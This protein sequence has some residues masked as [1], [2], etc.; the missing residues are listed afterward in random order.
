[1]RICACRSQHAD[2]PFP[3]AKERIEGY[4]DCYD[5]PY[6]RT[7]DLLEEILQNP[8]R[9]TPFDEAF[10]PHANVLKFVALWGVQL[11]FRLRLSP[12]RFRKIAPRFADFCRAYL[13]ICGK[14][15]CAARRNR[16]NAKKIQKFL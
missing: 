9:D 1:M 3:I 11:L 6:R 5:I 13:R 12:A 10:T 15:L 8:P 16:R 14:G 7:A 4:F 2:A